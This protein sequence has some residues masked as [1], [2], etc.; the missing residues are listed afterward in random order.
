MAAQ[1]RRDE[2]QFLE[3]LV[4]RLGD[5]LAA[6]TRRAAEHA[7]R[8]VDQLLAAIVPVIHALGAHDE[9]RRRL[10]FAVRRE[11]H[12]VFIKRNRSWLWLIVKLVFGV[13]HLWSPVSA[14]A[15]EPGARDAAEPK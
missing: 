2:V 6:V 11:R 4:H 8:R 1:K 7:R 10:E 5:F 12:P 3:L 14:R 13:A 9:H 15:V